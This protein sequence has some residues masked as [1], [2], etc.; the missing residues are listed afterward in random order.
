MLKLVLKWECFGISGQS[1]SKQKFGKEWSETQRDSDSFVI[2]LV[3]VLTFSGHRNNKEGNNIRELLVPDAVGQFGRSF[4]PKEKQTIQNTEVQMGLQ[5]L[6]G[7][8]FA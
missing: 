1:R 6:A 5:Q 4:S 8:K 2:L 7:S 3:A